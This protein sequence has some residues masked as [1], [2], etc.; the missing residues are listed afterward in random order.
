MVDCGRLKVSGEG[1]SDKDKIQAESAVEPVETD[2]H[3]QN[4]L[5]SVR[6][7]KTPRASI[8]DGFS[9]AVAGIMAA[10]AMRTGRRVTFDA[11]R[12]EIV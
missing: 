4:F 7:R 10:E 9:H 5:R 3:M 8:Q 12:L 2:T 11:D 6:S 1:S